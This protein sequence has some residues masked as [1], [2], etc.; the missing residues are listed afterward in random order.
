MFLC[1]DFNALTLIQP[2]T[3]S[4]NDNMLFIIARAIRISQAA[5]SEASIDTIG[6]CS[7]AASAATCPNPPTASCM[8]YLIQAQIFLPSTSSCPTLVTPNT[9][10]NSPSNDI[11]GQLSS[12]ITALS[13]SLGAVATY[14][15]FLP[16]RLYPTYGTLICTTPP[17]GWTS[18]QP[19]YSQMNNVSQSGIT[20]VFPNT[21]CTVTLLLGTNMILCSDFTNAAISSTLPIT[22]S[23]IN[24]ILFIVVRATANSIA[25]TFESVV[26]NVGNCQTTATPCSATPIPQPSPTCL[27]F[28]VQKTYCFVSTNVVTNYGI[29][30]V[31][32]PD[33]PTAN[34]LVQVV[35][36]LQLTLVAASM[37]R[38]SSYTDNVIRTQSTR[39]SG[40]LQQF[41]WLKPIYLYQNVFQA[42][43]QNAFMNGLS[44]DFQCTSVQD[45][46][47]QLA[48]Q[49]IYLCGGY[50]VYA[51]G[52]PPV[53]RLQ[54]PDPQ[55][56]VFNSQFGVIARGVFATNLNT[57]NINTRY[58]T[59]SQCVSNAQTATSQTTDPNCIKYF[60][61]AASTVNL[62]TPAT[63][64]I[65]PY[66]ASMY[67]FRVCNSTSAPI[68]PYNLIQ[69]LS[70][71]V[72]IFN[73]LMQTL[74]YLK[75]L[76]AANV[77]IPA[78]GPATYLQTRYAQ[79]LGDP[80]TTAPWN[81]IQGVFVS[82]TN[83]YNAQT[84]SGLA[85]DLSRQID[86]IYTSSTPLC[87][88]SIGKKD[89]TEAYTTNNRGYTVFLCDPFIL[90][91][92]QLPSSIPTPRSTNE[93]I[94]TTTYTCT[95]ADTHTKFGIITH[96]LTHVASGTV[97][98][99]VG[100]YD[101]Y[102]YNLAT[103]LPI[104]ATP[105]TRAT[106]GKLSCISWVNGD[107]SV[108]PAVPSHPNI[109]VSSDIVAD[110]LTFFIM[111]VCADQGFCK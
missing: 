58:T 16:T 103:I 12:A 74:N 65:S 68:P 57:V 62:C 86:I 34:N 59:Y 54:F 105:T 96:E 101:V 30:N 52:P 22:F 50:N 8:T 111:G 90:N 75:G 41:S 43:I 15:L 18:L 36:Q 55:N 3:L 70:Y 85:G 91:P 60:L 42:N 88:E 14:N 17:I 107:T 29:L 48:Q 100:D 72:L 106:S 5:T 76:S 28:L 31:C 66:V 87:F 77:A 38:P 56:G 51:S 39:Y 10:C 73:P 44:F 11:I 20:F 53:S 63:V 110:C 2:T 25:T 109:V 89:G 19:Q 102:G 40:L 49:Y 27:A 104:P 83:L 81:I 64:P 23:D 45:S 93:C 46:N 80:T 24:N 35:N 67:A 47:I 108:L 78:M 94:T 21:P 79:M 32:A 99:Y 33:A 92:Y 84:S 69:D 37:V 95:V 7:S 26:S 6:S 1:S 9:V 4:D 13:T 98:K 97:D 61:E 82:M 71:V